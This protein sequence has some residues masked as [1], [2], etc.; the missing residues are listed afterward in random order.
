LSGTSSAFGRYRAMTRLAPLAAA[1]L[2][3]GCA[4]TYV[5]PVSV[6]RFVGEQ[7]ARLGQGP[8]AVR[9]AAGMPDNS[10]E[11]A[12]YRQAVSSELT[13]LGYQVVPGNDAAQ[14]AEVRLGRAIEQGGR[15]RSPVSVG[16]GGSTGSYGSGVGLGIGIDLSGPPPDIAHT[17]MGV[18]IRDGASGRALWEGRAEFSASVNTPYGNAQAAARKMAVALFAG[19]P[20]RSGETVEVR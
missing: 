16:A 12:P 7:P 11:F 9:L 8:I 3:A 20:G 10:L 6:T 15:R 1:L 5:S 4:Q 17:Q 18:V 14:V 2:L 19:F 13:R